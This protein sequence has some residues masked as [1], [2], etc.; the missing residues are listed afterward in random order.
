MS[1]P[2]PTIRMLPPI[3]QP[4][5]GRLVEIVVDFIRRRLTEERRSRH[6]AVDADAGT[7]VP[8]DSEPSG[9]LQ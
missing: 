5:S 8:A 4:D 7:H 6:A 3:G 9:T 2:K 1:R